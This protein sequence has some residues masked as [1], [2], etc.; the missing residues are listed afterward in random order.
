MNFVCPCSVAGWSGHLSRM[1]ISVQPWGKAWM[2]I[3]KATGKDKCT[4][5]LYCLILWRFESTYLIPHLIVFDRF[6]AMVH[7]LICAEC[8]FE[9]AQFNTAFLCEHSP[10][11]HMIMYIYINI[12]HF[13]FIFHNVFW[14]T[15]NVK[16]APRVFIFYEYSPFSVDPYTQHL[17][18]NACYGTTISPFKAKILH[19]MVRHFSNILMT[20]NIIAWLLWL[21]LFSIPSNCSALVKMGDLF[22]EEH[23]QGKRDI[24]DIA[25]MYKKAALKNDP[26]VTHIRL[27]RS[28]CIS[29]D[30]VIRFIDSNCSCTLLVWHK[31]T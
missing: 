20:F 16:S 24:S 19:L 13:L 29:P 18:H 14:A 23:T 31:A 11:S 9:A 6:M 21:M 5:Q 30:E 15:E 22:Y 17:Q 2:P 26:Q 10:V 12:T 4:S 1:D 25:E 8:G 28:N 27:E 7:Y 3:S